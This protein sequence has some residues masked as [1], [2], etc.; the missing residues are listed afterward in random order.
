MRKVVIFLAVLFIYSSFALAGIPEDCDINMINY[1]KLNETS[2]SAIDYVGG[3]DGTVTGAT[4]GVTGQVDTAYYFDGSDDYISAGSS[5]LSGNTGPFTVSA[6]FN[7][8]T[9]TVHSQ[10]IVAKD[11]RTPGN[12]KRMFQI[13]TFNDDVLAYVWDDSTGAYLGK[14]LTNYLIPNQWHHVALVYHGG[15]DVRLYVDGTERT[16]VFSGGTFSGI[17]NTDANFMI[18]IFSLSGS[19]TRDFNGMIDEVTVHNKALASSEVQELYDLGSQNS[20]YCPSF[21]E[22]SEVPEVNRNHTVKNWILVAILVA[23]IGI[24]FIKKN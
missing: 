1:W 8:D 18:G 10:T 23:L 14:Q 16:T 19:L 20:S 24:I 2:G 21:V 17:D 4:Q 13:Q 5:V 7:T 12:S 11:D 15:S 3:D 22:Q 6:W 9:V